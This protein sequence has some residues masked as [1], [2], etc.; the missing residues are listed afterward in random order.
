MTQPYVARKLGLSKAE[1]QRKLNNKLKFNEQQLRC[2]VYLVGA[3]RAI[4]IIYFPTMRV[5]KMIIEKTFGINKGDK[6]E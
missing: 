6:H 2:L 4:D 3:E 5:K 1:L